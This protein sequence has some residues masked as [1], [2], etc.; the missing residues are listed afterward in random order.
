MVRA[1]SLW[2]TVV[3]VALGG[4]DGGDG[5]PRQAIAGTV[6]LDGKPLDYGSILFTTLGDGSTMSGGSLIADGRYA[7][8]RDQGLVPGSYRV[9]IYA[10]D[11]G[12]KS[13]TSELPTQL[14]KLPTDRIPP[15][16]NMETTLTAQ[17][18][19]G[20]AN[21]FVFDLKSR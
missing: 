8:A 7:I 12:S 10:P 9:A 14:G 16:Y 11:V 13:S 19:K 17:V 20:G 1:V 15:R 6:T 3:I 21:D 2:P 18:E 4:C 5:L